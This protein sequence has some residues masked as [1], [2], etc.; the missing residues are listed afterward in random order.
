MIRIVDFNDTIKFEWFKCSY[1]SKI[2]YY[3]VKAHYKKEDKFWKD[4]REYFTTQDFL[5]RVTKNGSTNT[6][7]EEEIVNLMRDKMPNYKFVETLVYLG[8][9]YCHFTP[10]TN[11]EL[12]V[13]RLS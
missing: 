3:D 12:I 9:K 13:D 8:E 1:G 7:N 10:K 11:T 5:V 6:F 4:V 2:E